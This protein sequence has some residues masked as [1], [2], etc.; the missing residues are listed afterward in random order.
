MA[1][2]LYLRYISY[3]LLYIADAT[4]IILSMPI[5]VFILA[6]IFLNEAFTRF[7][8]VTLCIILVGIATTSKVNL[9]F[10]I[11]GEGRTLDPFGLAAAFGATLVGA[12]MFII[13]RKLKSLSPAVILNNMA[14]IALTQSLILNF[15]FGE[16]SF[17]ACGTATWAMIFLGVVSFYGQFFLTLSL[18]N[19]EAGFVSIVRGSSQVGFAFIF[20]ISL[21][22]HVPDVYSICGALLVLF[23]IVL[24]GFRKYILGLPKDSFLRRKLFL[25]FK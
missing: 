11:G 9:L 5:F 25:F 4:V 1:S 12:F 21:L 13:G 23:G 24:I 2:N 17:P 10:G 6:K 19:E 15:F 3:Q 8:F 20:Q 22:H 18:R 14:W 7:H 16:F